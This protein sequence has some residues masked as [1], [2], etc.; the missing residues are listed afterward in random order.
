[1]LGSR[2]MYLSS[3][4]KQWRITSATWEEV[5]ARIARLLLD[6]HHL[7]LLG[8]AGHEVAHELLV[9]GVELLDADQSDVLRPR[10]FAR[11]AS[12]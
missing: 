7:H 9:E 2:P 12:S 1:M 8:V 6:V 11:S 5:A 4:P 10:Q 3:I